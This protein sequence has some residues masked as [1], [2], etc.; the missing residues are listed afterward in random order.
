MAACKGP[1]KGMRLQRVRNTWQHAKTA[2]QLGKLGRQMMM[3]IPG[4]T[5]GFFPVP[6][7]MHTVQGNQCVQVTNTHTNTRRHTHTYT[8]HRPQSC[9]QSP[10]SSWPPDERPPTSQSTSHFKQPR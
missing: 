1:G 7:A 5:L 3:F 2:C 8:H 6:R 9:M 4:K 10:C